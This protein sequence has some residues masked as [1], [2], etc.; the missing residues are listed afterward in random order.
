MSK[1][2]NF[3]SEPKQYKSLNSFFYVICLS[4]TY[5]NPSAPLHDVN[6]E[7]LGYELVRSDHPSQH[8]GQGVLQKFPSPENTKYSLLTR[9]YTFWITSWL[10]GSKICKF[11]SLYRSPSEASDELYQIINDP[12]HVLD[13]SLSCSDLIFYITTKVGSGFRCSSITPELN[14]QI[15]F[16][17]SNKEYGLTNKGTLNLLEQNYNERVSFYNKTISSQLYST[18][19]GIWQKPTLDKY[20]NKKPN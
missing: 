13:N 14:F 3:S 17:H 19:N 7:I 6:L 11:V 10:V 4:E 12:T 16:S 8:K 9:K 1:I 18:W 2:F 15:H 5:L 20:S